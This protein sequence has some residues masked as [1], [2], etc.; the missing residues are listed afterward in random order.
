MTY[1]EKDWYILIRRHWII[2]V[3]NYVKF[4]FHLWICILLLY[5]SIKFQDSL[6]HDF[7]KYIMFPCIFVILNYAFLRMA[8]EIIKYYNNLIIFKDREVIVIKTTLIDT[9]NVEIIDL[10]K[11]SKID[12][13]MQWIISN[14][15]AYW[16]LILE[17][18]R[19]R[20]RI[21][22]HI[23]KPYRAANYIKE[24]KKKLK[25]NNF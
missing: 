15:L 13:N 3:F 21:F 5:I 6:D 8:H 20:T 2:M 4:F 11:V 9:D 23:Y 24:L 1:Y 16:S 12:T 19:D 22:N 10:E 14:V 17:Q 18:Y 25:K 7:I